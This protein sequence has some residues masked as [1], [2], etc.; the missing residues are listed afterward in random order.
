M[1]NSVATLVDAEINGQAFL[2]GWRKQPSQTTGAGIWFDLSMSPGNPVPNY[3]A[4]VPVTATA[5]TDSVNRGIPHGSSVGSLGYQ[6]YLKSLTAMTVTATAVPLPMILC[7]YLMFYSFADM[8]ITDPQPFTTNI[9]LPRYPTGAGVKIMA[10]EV[11]A[12]SGAGNPQFIVN[13]TNQAG[14]Q[15]RVSK[16]QACNTQTVNGTIINTA[17]AT[18]FTA[19]PFI[20]L[21]DGDTGVRQIDSVQFFTPDIG[22]IAFVLVRPLATHFIRAIDAPAERNYFQDFSV[23]PVIQDNAYLN[24]IVLPNGTLSAVNIVGTIQTVW[25]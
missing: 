8:S 21:Q 6:K 1:I 15:G 16:T 7:D 2:S 13:Y 5:L 10:V 24:F 4:A 17:V 9:T 12:Q 14:Q 11:A 20:P 3:Y 18:A 25:G 22:L 23:M 19:G